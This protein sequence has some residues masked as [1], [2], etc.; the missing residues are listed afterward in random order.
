MKYL[1]DTNIIIYFLKQHSLVLK[2][3]IN[4]QHFGDLAVSTI[5]LAELEFGIENSVK[6]IENR[7]RLYAG[8][9]AFERVPFDDQ[10]AV[11]YGKIRADL[12]QRGA[13]IGPMD[14]QIAATA[15]VKDLILVTNNVRE[16]GR[17]Q[18]LLVEDWTV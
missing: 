16:F 6:K 4:R 2:R 9:A 8:L 1:I 5:T 15:L 14:L 10:C 18:G 17:V 13:I 7:Q 11:E 12:K 3:K